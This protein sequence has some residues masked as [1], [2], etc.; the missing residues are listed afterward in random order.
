MDY[1]AARLAGSVRIAGQPIA[2]GRI[3]FMPNPGT[4]G[5]PVTAEVSAGKYIAE[6][7]PLGSVV[8][9]FSAV[10]ETGKQVREQVREA[11]RD[12]YPEYV[13]I[14]PE[15]YVQ[16]VPLNVTGDNDAQDFDLTTDTL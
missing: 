15:K 10:K 1:P 13:S 3:H 9:T 4:P 2:E 16:G 5:L 12:P 6:D 11:G 7:V 8:V 14:I